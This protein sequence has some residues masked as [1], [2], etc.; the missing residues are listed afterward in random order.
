MRLFASILLAGIFLFVPL[1][2]L[3]QDCLS[4]EEAFREAESEAFQLEGQAQRERSRMQYALTRYER[5]NSIYDRRRD[6]LKSQ[7]ARLLAD[8][9]VSAAECYLFFWRP[10]PSARRFAYRLTKL[11]LQ[12]RENEKRRSRALSVQREKIAADQEA[13][14]FLY[15]QLGMARLRSRQ[16]LNEWQNCLSE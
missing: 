11:E 10:C 12:L 2:G 13:L 6:R 8:A 16:A 3:A 7:R 1:R 4:E 9:G 14:N 15:A 5:V